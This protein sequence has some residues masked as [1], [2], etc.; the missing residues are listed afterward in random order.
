MEKVRVK[1]KHV[2]IGVKN[3]KFDDE[4]TKTS[5]TEKKIQIVVLLE[6]DFFFLISGIKVYSNNIFRVFIL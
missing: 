5:G 3:K 1:T 2:L 6:C 4:K